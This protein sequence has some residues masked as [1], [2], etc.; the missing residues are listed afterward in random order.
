[1]IVYKSNYGALRL[2]AHLRALG[3][4]RVPWRGILMP[5]WFHVETETHLGLT[6]FELGKRCAEVAA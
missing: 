4:R 3:F 6:R 1:M 5:G 2:A